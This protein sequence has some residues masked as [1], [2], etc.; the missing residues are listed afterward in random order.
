MYHSFLVNIKNP[1]MRLGY[2]LFAFA[3]LSSIFQFYFVQIAGSYFS[4]A[5]FSVLLLIPWAMKSIN[6]LTWKPLLFLVMV[7][8]FQV[9]SFSWSVDLKL[10]LRSVLGIVLFLIVVMSVYEITRKYPERVLYVFLLYFVFVLSQAF[11]VIYFYFNPSTEWVFIKSEL[12]KVFI[13]PNTIS[14][15]FDGSEPHAFGIG[16]PGGF[17]VN[18][19]VGAAFLGINALISYGFSK[20]Y[21]IGWLKVITLIL[22]VGVVFSGSKAGLILIIFLALLALIMSKHIDQFLTLKRAM[23]VLFVIS[24]FCFILLILWNE[25]FQSNFINNTVKTTDSRILIWSFGLGEFFKHPIAGLGFGGWQEGFSK[26]AVE[27]G[28]RE[29][30][31]PHNTFIDLWAQSGIFSVIFALLFMLSILKHGFNL[32]MAQNNELLGIGIAVLA[33]FLW[34]FIHGMGTNFGLVG[35]LHMEIIL[36]ALLGYSLARLELN[37]MQSTSDEK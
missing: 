9:L 35:E 11:L 8:I 21:S 20:A 18:R 13:N 31:P 22:M 6:L 36:A 14:A 24:I 16:S 30:F 19:N 15:I 4:L 7:V 2:G 1:P 28:I 33:A 5:L 26:Y 34:V 10:G 25:V 32:I 37:T 17:F 12:A 3:L 27:N 29:G 23:F